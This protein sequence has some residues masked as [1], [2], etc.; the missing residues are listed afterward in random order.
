MEWFAN[1][2][3]FRNTNHAVYFLMCMV[4]L[5]VFL[6]LAI[7]AKET[8]WL[9]G[10][11]VAHLGVATAAFDEVVVKKKESRTY[12]KDCIW[13]NCLMSLVCLGLGIYFTA[14]P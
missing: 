4:G 1:T 7:E 3:R 9:F 10:G 2:F 8:G 5:G 13:F 12:S 11:T 14:N 6:F